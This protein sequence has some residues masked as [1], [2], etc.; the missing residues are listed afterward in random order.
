MDD[1]N[2]NGIKYANVLILTLLSGSKKKCLHNSIEVHHSYLVFGFLFICRI[3][4][5]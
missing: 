2:R 3:Y 4:I 1:S 5:L